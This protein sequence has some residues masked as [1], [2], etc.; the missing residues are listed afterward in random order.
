MSKSKSSSGEEFK[1]SQEDL[2]RTNSVTYVQKS[3]GLFDFLT[4]AF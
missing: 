3:R 2:N 4:E 1:A